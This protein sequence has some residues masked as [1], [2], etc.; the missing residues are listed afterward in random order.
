VAIIGILPTGLEVQKDN[1]EDT[2]INHDGPLMM[3]A[4]Q[5]ANTNLLVLTNSLEWIE[6]FVNGTFIER[7]PGTNLTSRDIL[8]LFGTPKYQWNTTT[9]TNDVYTLRAKY[10]AGSGPLSTEA[11]NVRDLAFTYLIEPVIV[12]FSG[13]GPT[14][15]AAFNSNMRTNLWEMRLHLRWPVFDRGTNN[16][17]TGSGQRVFRTLVSGRLVQEGVVIPAYSPRVFN[18]YYFTPD[19][20]IPN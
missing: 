11:T 13:N 2:I 8:G 15:P 19:I 7:L 10:R 5:H 16:V 3:E 17:R 18:M 4:I 20:Y 6:T 1:R 9:L 14:T 12:P